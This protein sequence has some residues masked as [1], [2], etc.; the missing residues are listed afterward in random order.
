MSISKVF[1]ALLS[2]KSATFESANIQ[3]DHAVFYG[4]LRQHVRKCP[5]CQSQDVSIKET[6]E[7]V[8]RM[9][10]LGNKRAYLK[11]NTYKVWCQRCDAKV[12]LKLPFTI[13]KL[14]MTKSFMQYIVQL[15]AITTLLAVAILLGL[16]WNT[17]KN[18]DKANLAKRAKQF[19]FKKLRYLSID[20][21]AIKK[22]HKYMTI[23]SDISTG[24]IIHAVEGRKE[25]ALRPF[26]KQLAKKARRLRGIAIDMSA[27]YASS[28]RLHL[29]NVEIIF[30][31]F[32]VTKLL[33][34]TIDKIRRFEY[35]RHNNKGLRVLKGQRFLL[36]R[37]FADLDP[38]QQDHLKQLL[39]INQP[40]AIAH[41]MKEQFRLFWS[42]QSRL[43]GARF[44][45]LWIITAL[46]S[47][48]AL[49]AK[50]AR[51]FLHRAAG[52]LSYFD[53]RI[54]NGKAEGI[55]NKIK[56]LKRQAYGFRDQEYFKLRLYHLHKQ[57]CR[58]VG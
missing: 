2:D 20:E 42:C 11:I 58:L 26:L 56:V 21:I 7:R 6:K 32:H 19:S 41:S 10:N 47:G 35:A 48:V 25:E 51:T 50:T 3:D 31:R 27:A 52:L 24:R 8:F 54:D 9:L 29:P 39:E 5:C 45:A 46:D 49:L 44:L 4:H 12:W 1:Y 30:D 13:G 23:F 36:L 17:V 15:T 33:T 40:L 53:H 22:G 28:V 34:D 38:A 57:E 55:N 16:Q 37:N 18:I 43:E 14:P